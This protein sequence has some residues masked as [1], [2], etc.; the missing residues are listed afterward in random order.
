MRRKELFV[1]FALCSAIGSS[2]ITPSYA[3]PTYSTEKAEQEIEDLSQNQEDRQT[4]L[5]AQEN[6]TDLSEDLKDDDFEDLD[7]DE[8]SE[9]ILDVN[10]EELVD[11]VKTK[12]D[13]EKANYIEYQ[14]SLIH[15]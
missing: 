2:I 5:L 6:N 4:M 13:L 14:L 3:E 11:D 10:V 15:I 8:D 12:D 1:A 7:V 9:P